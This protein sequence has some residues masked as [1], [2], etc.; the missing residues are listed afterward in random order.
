MF[1]DKKMLKYIVIYS[2][3][4]FGILLNEELGY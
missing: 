4:A 2:I 3:I 1:K